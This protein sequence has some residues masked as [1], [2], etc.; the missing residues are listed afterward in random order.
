MKKKT[1]K[2][3]CDLCTTM[4]W[5]WTCRQSA[6]NPAITRSTRHRL[7]VVDS[8]SSDC[9]RQHAFACCMDTVSIQLDHFPSVITPSC[10]VKPAI[11]LMAPQIIETIA[12]LTDLNGSFS[13]T[14]SLAIIH[15]THPA[16]RHD[17][18]WTNVCLMLDQRLRCWPGNN[19]C[20]AVL[21]VNMLRHLK[22]EL[23]TQFP[24]SND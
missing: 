17:I 23:L 4:K 6:K 11:C 10:S 1:L 18:H 22:L 2:Q 20:S 21:S 14:F 7:L 8:H 15:T 9:V 12:S 19:P 3:K 16:T 24:T 5:S 13:C